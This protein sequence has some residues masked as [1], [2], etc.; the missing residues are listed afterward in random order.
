MAFRT[1]GDLR[2]DLMARLG[3]GAQGASGASQTLMNSF[4]R[5]GQFQL[6]HAQDWKHLTDYANKTLGVGQN[7]LDYPTAGTMNTAEGCSRDKRI[8]Y[9][10]TY[11]S[12]QWRR[13]VEGITTAHWNTMDTQSYP[14]RFERFA[15]LL[16]YP[17]A[18]QIYTVRVWYVK[19]LAPFTDD[20][21]RCDM[22]DEMVLLHAVTNAKAH[23]RHPDAKLYEGQLSQ[24]MSSLRSKSF[25]SGGQ[26]VVQR[27][28]MQEPEV[29][30]AVVGRDV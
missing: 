6:Y 8:L 12:G 3:M 21:H 25:G 5:N 23:Y 28:D 4:L 15:Q 16:V 22:D 24:L 29:R 7:L 9:V 13:L 30:P 20:G 10:E 1:L 17:K 14:V 19:D 2:S 11:Y 26:G 18:D 27:R